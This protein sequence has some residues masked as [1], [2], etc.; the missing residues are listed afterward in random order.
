LGKAE[1]ETVNNW[2]IFVSLGMATLIWSQVSALSVLHT[3]IK[4]S[5]HGIKFMT[6]IKN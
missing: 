5:I 4:V 6:N 1:L 3:K 2:M